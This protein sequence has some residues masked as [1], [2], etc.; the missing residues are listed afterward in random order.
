MKITP[1]LA[2]TNALALAL[3]LYL[4]VELNDLR[5]QTGASRSDTGDMARQ[6]LV[7]R[8]DT[9]ERDLQRAL[10]MQGLDAMPEA[11]EGE[12]M[13]IDSGGA[14]ATSE[15]LPD[16]PEPSGATIGDEGVEAGAASEDLSPREM[17]I[18]RQRVKKAIEL[19]AEEDQKNRVIERIDQLIQE[20]KIAS[21]NP[22]Q[23]EGVATTV[24]AY[25]RK[26]PDVWRKLREEGALENVSREDRGRIVRAEYETLRTETQHALE[27]FMP[28]VDAKT[29][30][31][32]TMRDQMRG[33]FG[34]SFGGPPTA[35][36]RGR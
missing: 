4:Y 25:R 26:V 20:N 9:L 32:E 27:E 22:R 34:G 8:V 30:L 36:G 2:I 23:K 14:H 29:Y 11:R 5:S 33:G 18:F 21:L 35:P 28:A 31:D 3:A 15:A 24:L 12:P 17:D 19:N 6:A 10:A 7:A 16:D 1:I 13:R